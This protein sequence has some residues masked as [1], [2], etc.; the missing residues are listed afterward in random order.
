LKQIDQ[1]G[2]FVFSKVVSAEIL[3]EAFVEVFPTVLR[4]GE[5]VTIRLKQDMEQPA[6]VK[7]INANGQ[8]VDN[9]VFENLNAQSLVL[10]TNQLG[11]GIYFV[12]MEVGN[13]QV[14]ERVVV[15]D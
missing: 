7:I 14:V 11:A 5:S 13:V 6:T 3:Q 8:I 12:Q 4:N 10:Q 9:Q 1:A 2:N 15:I